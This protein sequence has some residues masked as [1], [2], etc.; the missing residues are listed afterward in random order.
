MKTPK[1]HNCK[2]CKKEMTKSCYTKYKGNC[3]KCDMK[4][5]PQNWGSIE[6]FSI[7]IKN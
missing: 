6:M 7:P 5:N 4:L 3:V 1:D 2:T